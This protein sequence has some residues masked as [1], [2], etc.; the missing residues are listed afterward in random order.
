MI[1]MMIKNKISKKIQEINCFVRFVATHFIEDDC[2]YRASA[3]A[4]T[5]ILALVPLMSVSFFVLSAFP[6]FHHLDVPIQNFIFEN[7]VPATGKIVQEYLQLFAT[8]V[9]KLSIIGVVFLFLF[10]LLLLYTIETALN[11]IWH[12]ESSRHGLTA[13]L[14]YWTI[15]SLAL[16][17]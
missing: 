8:Q 12:A 17:Y 3:L 2:S 16:F 13:F 15:V 14:L 10:T 1:K 11:R 6:I 4:F 9:T 5:T 7:F